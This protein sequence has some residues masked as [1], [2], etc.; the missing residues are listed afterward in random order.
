MAE[1]FNETAIDHMGRSDYA[2][3][4][5]GEYSVKLRLS[6]LAEKYPDEVKMI[7][8][9]TDGSVYYHVPWKW[10][11]I[12]PPR[13]IS[14]EQRAASAERLRLARERRLLGEGQG[15]DDGVDDDDL[16]ELIEDDFG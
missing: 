16:E 1:G 4:S 13:Q 8:D 3:V 5:T 6:R 7:A 10:I 12:R 9:N 2:G 11:K 14:E 15:E